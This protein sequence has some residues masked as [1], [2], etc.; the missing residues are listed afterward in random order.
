[1]TGLPFGE[2]HDVRVAHPAGGGDDRLVARVDGG[3]QRVEDHLLAAGGDQ[4]L[5][6]LVLDAVVAA[7]LL[8]DR[9]PQRHRAGD[10]GVLRL[11]ALDAAIARP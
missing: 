10:V 8:A 3:D 1:M 6:R 11:A 2:R 5:L 7:E 4:D 9:L